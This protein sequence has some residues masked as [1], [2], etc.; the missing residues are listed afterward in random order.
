MKIGVFHNLPSGGAKRTLQEQVRRLAQEHCVDVFSI[1][2]ADHE[3]ADLRPFVH[4]HRIFNFIPSPLFPSPF[5][6]INQ[7]SRIVDLLRM[8]ALT[9][10]ISGEIQQNQFDVLMVHPCQYENASSIL[11]HLK[12]MPTIYYC[13]EPLRLV[14]ERMPER[15]YDREESSRRKFFNSLDPLPAS[16]REFRRRLDLVNT[17]SAGIVLVNSKYVQSTVREIYRVDAQVSYHGVDTNVFKP[18]GLEKGNF[19]LS[20]GS[21]TP[22]KGFDFLIEVLS[23]MNGDFRPELVIASN[24]QNPLEHEYLLQLADSFG[25]KVRF[26]SNVSDQYLVEL[27]NRARVT[28]YTPIREPFGLVSLESMACGTPVIAIREGGIQETI[29]DGVTGYLIERDVK[30]FA[31]GLQRMLDDESLSYTMGLRGREHVLQHWSWEKSINSLDGYL[32]EVS[33]TGL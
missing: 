20:V 29:L 8:H 26:L 31:Q 33:A 21:L 5:G 27:Y 19:V 16:Y 17:R 7:I 2:S 18:L 13:H 6:R 22:L 15:P 4:G 25:V 30:E 24:F 28:V 23:K 3:F 11:R 9:R 32:R 14:Y 10:H 1:S 12:K